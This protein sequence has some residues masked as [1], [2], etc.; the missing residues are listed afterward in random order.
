M[1]TG[2]NM[3]LLFFQ[4]HSFMNKGIERGLKEL[5]IP[6]DTFFISLTTGKRMMLF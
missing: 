6:Y 4:W 3:K 1:N 2:R 5:E